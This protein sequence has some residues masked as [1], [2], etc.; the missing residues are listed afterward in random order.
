MLQ[1]FSCLIRETQQETAGAETVL[2]DRTQHFFLELGAHAWQHTQLLF[3]AKL[4]ELVDGRDP[5]ML[6]DQSD[7]LGTE[8]LDF[9]KFE[10]GRR[11]LLEQH[12]A[13]LA[14]A[15]IDDLL[16][17][18]GETLTNAGNFSDF[19]FRVAQDVSDALRMAFDGGRAVAVTA[20]T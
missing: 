8:A 12:V 18:G 1:F 4:L 16:Q 15:A 7:A 17:H 6:E 14:G 3:L 5:V 10:R 2:C 20:N 19:A 9:Q 13:A 11:E